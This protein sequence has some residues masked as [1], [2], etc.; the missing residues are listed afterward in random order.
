MNRRAFVSLGVGAAIASAVIQALPKSQE[1]DPVEIYRA[2][3]WS[4]IDWYELKPGDVFRRVFAPSPKQEWR[5]KDYGE[6]RDTLIC[7][8]V[9]LA[10]GA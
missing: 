2:G 5:V 4:A 8:P 3:V 9:Q 7:S 1:E 6:N 10:V